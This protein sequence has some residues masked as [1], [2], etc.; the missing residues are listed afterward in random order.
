MEQD[1]VVGAW[2][3]ADA[4]AELSDEERALLPENPA[5]A[6]DLTDEALDDVAGGGSCVAW[7]CSNPTPTPG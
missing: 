2:K 6:A 3:D 5:G 1:K 7:S 4:R